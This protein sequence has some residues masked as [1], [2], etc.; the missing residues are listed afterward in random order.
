M[1]FSGWVATFAVWLN[2]LVIFIT[3]GVM[4]H[5]PPNFAIA[6]LGSAGSMFVHLFFFVAIIQIFPKNGLL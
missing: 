2:L 6:T 4:A 5:S 3:M 1:C